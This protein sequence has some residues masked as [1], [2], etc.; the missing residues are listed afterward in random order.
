VSTEVTGSS[1]LAELNAQ[2]LKNTYSV[3]DI[4]WSIVVDSNRFWAPESLISISHLPVYREM[5][6]E[7]KLRFNQYNALSIAEAFMF[8]E[9]YALAPSLTKAL[10]KVNDVDFRKALNNFI[11]EEYKHSLCFKKLL[12]R[13]APHFYNEQNFKFRFLR[14]NFIGRFVF[15]ILQTFPKLL[16][17]WVWIA[18]FFEERT[19]M[20][21]KEYF[22]FKKKKEDQLDLLF[23]QVHYF[24]MLDEVRHVR[25]DEHMLKEFYQTYNSW[26]AKTV[27]WVVGYFVRRVSYPIIRIQSCLNHI[28]QFHPELLS[29]ETEKR[30]YLEAK[31]LANSASFHEQNFSD[32]AVP[33][34]RDL[35]TRFPEFNQFWQK[36]MIVK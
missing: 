10:K 6:H 8:F 14:V 27:A 18:L 2:A 13:A 11:D 23:Y 31:Q 7:L 32:A 33:R 9:E 1:N 34:T 22:K 16:P 29:A 5:S 15:S 20:Y 17:A 35:M 26:H 36:I 30:I 25:L 4:D 21:S 28:K 12:L 3:D 24:H 19:L